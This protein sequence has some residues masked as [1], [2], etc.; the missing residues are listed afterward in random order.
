MTLT[1]TVKL[2]SGEAHSV[3]CS[4]SQTVWDFKVRV[5]QQTGVSP[6]L[7]KLARADG[8]HLDLRDDAPL[9]DFGLGSG[10]TLLL[11]VK[12]EESI[13]ILVKNANHRTSTYH[14]LP[15]DTVAHL[16]ARIRTQERIQDGQ[17]WLSYG[18][19]SLE[20]RRKLSDYNICPGATVNLNLRMRG[21]GRSLWG[22]SPP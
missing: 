21:G 22:G 10:D 14:V 20:E 13:P 4:P 18:S 12:Q 5:G 15:S 2:L 3:S 16:R 17:F 9:A 19:E 7:Q 11:L 8:A 6:Y 1:L